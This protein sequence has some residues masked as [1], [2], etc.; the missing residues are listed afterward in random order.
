[1]PDLTLSLFGSSDRRIT[2]PSALVAE[3]TCAVD[4]D[5][6]VRDRPVLQLAP[7]TSPALRPISRRITVHN[8]VLGYYSVQ[9]SAFTFIFSCTVHV[10]AQWVVSRLSMESCLLYTSDAAD[11]MD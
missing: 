4:Q 1:M 7:A 5:N 3:N 11:E 6:F 2:F 10:P 9:M 8:A